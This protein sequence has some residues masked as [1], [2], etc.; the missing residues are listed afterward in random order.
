MYSL[1][2]L[3]SILHLKIIRM[4]KRI[5][6]IKIQHNNI[7]YI[8]KSSILFSIYQYAW[9]RQTVTLFVAW[10]ERKAFFKQPT[11]RDHTVFNFDYFYSKLLSTIYYSTLI[12]SVCSINKCR[13]VTEQIKL[14][15]IFIIFNLQIIL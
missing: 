8:S 4:L 10:L 2:R 14:L 12:L 1:I 11:V 6:Q 7:L 5:L 3:V 13:G 9:S 15:K